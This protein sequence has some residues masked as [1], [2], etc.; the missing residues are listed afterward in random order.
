MDE[1]EL[2]YAYLIMDRIFIPEA[3]AK[4]IA[5]I[6]S[7]SSTTRKNLGGLSEYIRYGASQR[8]AISIAEAST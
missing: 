7:A 6:V 5:R 2:N 1:T 8:V 4:Y 3:V